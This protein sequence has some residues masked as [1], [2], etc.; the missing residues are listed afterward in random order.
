MKWLIVSQFI[1]I[2]GIIII[3][4]IIIIIKT[5]NTGPSGKN[6]IVYE[7]LMLPNKHL[8][9][10]KLKNKHREAINDWLLP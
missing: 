4:N 8:R 3:N 6:K 10:G 1:T 9:H 7:F 2:K 5:S